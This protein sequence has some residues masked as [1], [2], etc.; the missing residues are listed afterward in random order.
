MKRP[1]AFTLI[2]LMVVIA[3]I[4]ILAGLLLPTL[5]RAKDR[6]K[7]AVCRNNLHQLTI[8]FALYHGANDDK[9]PA[10]GSSTKYGPQPEDWIWWHYGR[11]ITN[12]SIVPQLGSFSPQLFTCPS[13]TVARDL[14]GQG[15]LPNDPYRY[16]YALTSYDLNGDRNL[17][18]ATLI[19]TDRKVYPFRQGQITRPV[20]KLMLVEEDRG[21]IDDSRWVPVGPLTNLV[22]ERHGKKGNVAFADGHIE[23]VTPRFGMNITNSMPAY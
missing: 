15:L 23:S 18:M 16:S 12:S 17:G 19:T 20:L 6:G 7:Q 9:F 11:N 21:T 1:P 2:E 13:D 8:A 10:P 3:I 22:T 4:A 14:Q 5:S